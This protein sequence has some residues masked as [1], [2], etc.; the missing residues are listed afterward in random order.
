[1]NKVKV[2]FFSFTEITDPR[3]HRAYNEWHQ[4]DHMPE[5]LPLRGVAWGQRW[6]ATPACARARDAAEPPLDRVH[7]LTQYLM[8]DPVDATLDEFWRWG[9]QLNAMG[10]FHRHRASHLNGAFLLAE[11]YAARRIR[12]AAE[13]VPYRPNRGVIALL[14]DPVDPRELD[15][16]DQWLHL[17]HWPD[18]LEIPGVAGIWN[19]AE[20]EKSRSIDN[21]RSARRLVV[22]YLDD[23]PTAV[24]ERL[25]KAESG[26]RAAGR[27]PDFSHA[28]RT[29][30]RCPFESIVP[31]QWDWFDRS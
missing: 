20:L 8:T 21:R 24:L 9:A 29:L 5:Q 30:Y 28:I 16:Y 1:M 6:V 2:G 31:W 10:R 22:L 27:M 23:E 18:V 4:L 7:Y 17:T 13:A 25:R 12:I 26:W 19:F 14:Q 3:E 15:A 11:T